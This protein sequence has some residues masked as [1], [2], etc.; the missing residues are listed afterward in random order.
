MVVACRAA[1]AKREKFF[2]KKGGNHRVLYKKA[3]QKQSPEVL[4]KHKKLEGKGSCSTC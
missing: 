1:E 2:F 4:Q 3:D